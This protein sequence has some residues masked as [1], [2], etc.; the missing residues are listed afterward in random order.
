MILRHVESI[1]RES[2]GKVLAHR[3]KERLAK[4]GAKTIQTA[5]DLNNLLGGTAGFADAALEELEPQHPARQKLEKLSATSSRAME[6]CKTLLNTAHVVDAAYRVSTEIN[7]LIGRVGTLLQDIAPEK[8]VIKTATTSQPVWLRANAERLQQALLNLGF[9]IFSVMPGGGTVSLAVGHEDA[10]DPQHS[11]P[12]KTCVVVTIHNQGDGIPA[13]NPAHISDTGFTTAA[14][15]S[16]INLACVQEI[17][18]IEYNGWIH[19][20][21]ETGKGATFSLYL[22]VE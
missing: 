2:S 6:I 11:N 15:W 19:V 18:E 9:H 10:A 3:E 21:S 17:V 16:G 4:I 13:K 12:V 8:V 5:Y 20:E 1:F 22:P 7:T 14:G